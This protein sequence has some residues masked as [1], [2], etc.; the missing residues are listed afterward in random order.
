MKSNEIRNLFYKMLEEDGHT[1][2]PSDSL[3]PPKELGLLFSNA[4]MNQFYK[5]F[6]GEATPP[7]KRMASIQKCLRV[8]GKHNDFEEVGFSPHH[9]TFFEMIGYFSFGDYFKEHAIEL[10]WKFFTEILKIDRSKLYITVYKDDKESFKIWKDHI[11]ID[12]K[13]IYFLDRE[14]FWEMGKT[15]PCGPSTEIIYDLNGKG[16]PTVEELEDSYDYLELG[17]IV[18]TQFYKDETGNLLDLPQKNVDTG[19]GLER[20]ARVLQGSKTNFE[21]DLFFPIIRK[22]ELEMGNKYSENPELQP[23]FR[24]IADHI[25]AITFLIN[26]GINPSNI[27]KG[28]IVRKLIRRASLN[29]IK[30]GIDKPYLYDLV[31]K[32]EEIFHDVYT[33]LKNNKT[34]I[35][36]VV[37]EEEKRFQTLLARGY[38]KY[39]DIRDELKNNNKNT[40]DGKTLFELYDRLGFPVD[41]V[42]EMALDDNLKVD[43]SGF[44]DF[45]REQ[46]KRAK[47]NQKK[48]EYPNIM[49]IQKTKFTGYDEMSAKCRIIKLFS[50]NNAEVEELKEGETGYIVSD[51]TPF[52]AESGG[53]IGDKGTIRTENGI[54]TVLETQKE[55]DVFLHIGKVE[56]GSIKKTEGQFMVDKKRR[57]NIMAHHTLTHLLQAALREVLGE[58]C[59]QAGSFVSDD[60]LRF[61]FTHFQKLTSYEIRDIEAIVNEKI[62]D[63]LPVKITETSY[64]EAVNAGAMALFEGKYGSKVRQVEVEGFSLEL[65]G[66]TH[67]ANTIQARGFKIISE[68]SISSGIR[69][70]EAH[71]G[72]KYI[73]YLN[74]IYEKYDDVRT[75]LKTNEPRKEIERIKE[76]EKELM[77]DN[78]NLQ[79][80]LIELKVKSSIENNPVI[81]KLS[82]ELDFNLTRNIID[83]F[84]K[85]YGDKVFLVYQIK[86]EKLTFLIMRGEKV[87]L[88]IMAFTRPLFP[89]F[90]GGGG[91]RDDFIQ[92]GGSNPAGIQNIIEALKKEIM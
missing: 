76:R 31:G 39:T 91:G 92:C 25:R 88:D 1:I 66:G 36:K 24:I 43:I 28:Y 71:G 82:S 86:D 35:E 12:E 70:I 56:K 33:D 89:I 58:H 75:F 50:K 15:G 52:Y 32:V 11:G 59:H 74:N 80:E 81:I 51:K 38:K 53:Q 16:A 63:E 10:G 62:G 78:N 29:L 17:N 9:H 79:S 68:S 13:R 37:F 34:F 47:A 27:G 19:L 87:K 8:S 5:Y 55:T 57:K 65:C 21:T 49:E 85:K 26:D 7:D 40:I 48:R 83:G 54:F 18:F 20:I 30:L 69:R 64:D 22:L 6:S 3:I 73:E 2:I 60:I 61:D 77:K 67:L 44:D 45:M 46:K 84:R 41:L 4:G 72:A 42:K 90:K 14:N 23:P